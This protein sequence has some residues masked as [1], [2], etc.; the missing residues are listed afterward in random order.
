MRV[1]DVLSPVLRD[2]QRVNLVFAYDPGSAFGEGVL[3]LLQTHGALVM[4]WKQ[5]RESAPHLIVTATENAVLTDAGHDAPVLV[6]PHGVGFHKHVPDARGPGDR[7]AGLVPA[8]L[9]ASGRARTAISHPDQAAQLPASANPFF[10]GD[11][12]YDSLLAGQDVRDR[13][14]RALGIPANHRLV[15]ISSTWR[16]E[17][18]VGQDST[19][20]A[21]LLAQLPT[22]AYAVALVTHPNVTAAHGS[23]HLEHILGSARASGLIRIPPESGW[24]AALLAADLL[25]G[26]HGSVTFYGAAIGIPVLLGAFS[27]QEAVA[28]TP[29]AELGRLAPHLDPYA[30]LLA[31]VERTI[32][33]HDADR[34]CK[35]GAT[36]LAEPGSALARLRTAVYELLDLPEPATGPPTPL[37]PEDPCPVPPRDVS[38]ALS[39]T[40]RVDADLEAGPRVRIHRVPAAAVAPTTASEEQHLSCT[41]DDRELSARE[42]A[43]VLLRHSPCSATA[44]T[45]WARDILARY[46]GALLAATAVTAAGTYRIALRDGR[47]VEATVTGPPPDPGLPAAVVHACLMSGLPLDGFV[48]AAVADRSDED[49]SLRVLPQH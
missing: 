46:P 24:Q 11:P 26:D 19:L 41:D 8:E 38:T 25:I 16:D 32:E 17:S 39:V 13:Y 23:L 44:A 30:P 42:S 27:E 14:R 21:R 9:L 36:A 6:L 10:V 22:D 37:A 45:A 5:F 31:Q 2:D 48:T 1:L 18:A 43:S 15:L 35:L 34:M 20:P 33:S 28:G 4:P 29:M 40:T 3:P 12:C 47:T 49:V 7:L